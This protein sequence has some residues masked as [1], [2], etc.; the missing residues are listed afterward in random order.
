MDLERLTNNTVRLAMWNGRVSFPSQIP[1]FEKQPRSDIQWR[2]VGLYF[3]R[4]W[5]FREIG[6]RYNL[7][8]QRIMQIV[9]KWR[10]RA[11]KLGYIQ[12]VPLEDP[13]R[14]PARSVNEEAA[15]A[16]RRT[17]KRFIR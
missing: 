14:A 9:D 15:S 2:V 4:G 8:P 6:K 17:W 7:T 11:A 1:T 3:I 5:S 16:T 13:I 10:I 12:E